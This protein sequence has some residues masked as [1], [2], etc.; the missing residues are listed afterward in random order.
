MC[1]LFEDDM[2]TRIMAAYF[3]VGQDEDYPE[4]NFN[5]W[6][7]E[8]YGYQSFY[9]KRNYKRVNQ[10]VDVRADHA[11]I[12]HEVAAKS[13]VLL[14]NVD[15]ALPLR[16]PKQIAVFGSDAGEAEYGPNG[17]SDR[18]CNNG[19]LAVGWGSGS[20]NF[21]YLVTPL[22]AIKARALKEGSVV[23]S[24]L[25]DYAYSQVN[26]TAE[27]AS[28]CL[29]FVSADS[30]EGYISVD[31]NEGDRNNLTLWK[32]GDTLINTVAANCNN[33]V[34]VIHAV[35]T[36]LLEAFIDH[37]NVTAV[38]FAG[39][40]GQESGNALVDI[41]YGD[42]N[43]S[44]KLPFTMAKKRADYGVDVMY[45]P[46]AK[47]PQE[48]FSEGLFIDYRHF[49][50]NGIEPR[51]PF[52]FGMS[53]TTFKY[54]DLYIAKLGFPEQYSPSKG[55]SAGVGNSST[56]HDPAEFLP[57]ADFDDW[58]IP[59]F[60]YPY[61]NS[62]SDVKN[63]TYDAPE[64]AYDTAP[65][66]IPAAGGAPGGNPSLYEA[67]YEVSAIITNTGSYDGEEVVQL[68]LET[69]LEDDPV[70]VLR[71]FE[72]VNLAKGQ[73]TTVRIQL[74]RR[75]LMRWDVVTQDWILP[76]GSNMTVRVG[77]SSRDMPLVGK[78]Y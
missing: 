40:P 59:F 13:T 32:D 38:L 26:S 74:N 55:Y 49:D 17:C 33:T 73:S 8:E 5:S 28:V 15:G 75:D 23:Q 7:Y 44:G 18:G 19:T 45:T 42:V 50:K 70:V 68:Y 1:S 77:S 69:G 20:A 48:N 21:P 3:L 60:I 78:L 65:Q 72:K 52:G 30:G 66:P 64:D 10:N 12:I 53:Y 11:N 22:E 57:P 16:K 29:T 67:M 37:P 9:S 27:V 43:P 31:G 24:V 41:L 35:G 2:A 47:I 58:K 14:K 46:N 36:V 4:T 54:S 63:G 6:T 51:F 25:D 61:L 62:T 76:E 34:V 71:G 56:S 39:L